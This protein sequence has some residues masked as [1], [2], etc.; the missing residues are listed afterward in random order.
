MNNLNAV[1]HKHIIGHKELTDHKSPLRF[2][3]D[4]VYISA[5]DNKGLPLKDKLAAGEKVLRGTVLG[6]RPDFSIPVISSVSGTIKEV[7][8]LF[9]ST[10]G[11]PT[12]FFVIENDKKYE[13]V[14]RPLLKDDISKEEFISA[15]QNA[16]LVGMGGAGFPTYLKYK[17]D[18]KISYL[19]V[20][21]VE[22]EPY[23]T[24]DYKALQERLNSVIVGM[25][26]IVKTFG[27]D[28]AYLCFKKSK[29]DLIEPVKKAL[30][31]HDK[32]ELHLVPDVYPA[33]Y[34]RTLVKFVLKKTYNVLP[35][36]VGAVVNNVETIA[37][38][39]DLFI[40]TENLGFRTYTFSGDALKNNNNVICPV[41]TLIG[42]IIKFLGGYNTE[43]NVMIVIGGPMTGK[44]AR[45]EEI[46]LMNNNSGITVFNIKKL[47]HEYKPVACWHC[48]KCIEVCP[49]SLQPVLIRMALG[50]EDYKSADKLGIMSCVS[51][52]SCSAICPSHIDLAQDF[53][54]GKLITKIKVGAK[55]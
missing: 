13:A 32:L 44:A 14:D 11:R 10:L 25:E 51:C 38:I 33:G 35:I 45:S 20:N 21:A 15:V 30:Q 37:Q 43:D 41:G 49:S 23:L 8:K 55:K 5:V 1:G 39:G 24:T 46:A 36:E 26:K 22:C 52:G 4:F 12:D 42:E 53:A 9:N 3:P 27:L 50:R 29:K 34:E 18:K 31:G 17:T 7:K 28:K 2:D 48:G 40:G 6:T 19:I 54:K 16:G 47:E